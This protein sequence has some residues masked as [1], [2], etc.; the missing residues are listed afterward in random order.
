MPRAKWIAGPGRE[1][2]QG[3]IA[4]AES[5]LGSTWIKH[6]DGRREVVS[7]LLRANKINIQCVVSQEQRADT[8]TNSFAATFYNFTVNSC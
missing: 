8:P 4:L 6:V 5:V 1:D 2:N 7:E 3:A